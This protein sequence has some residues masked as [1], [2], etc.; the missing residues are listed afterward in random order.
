MASVVGTVSKHEDPDQGSG[1]PD[2]IE[3][4]LPRLAEDEPLKTVGALAAEYVARLN[5]SQESVLSA[6]KSATAGIESGYGEAMEHQRRK[7]ETG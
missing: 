7:P 4:A 1:I 2:A 3:E 6:M 5:G